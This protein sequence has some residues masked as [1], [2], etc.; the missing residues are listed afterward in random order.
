[1]SGGD[2]TLKGNFDSFYIATI[3]Q[4][5]SNDKKTGILRITDGDKG[6]QVFIKDGTIIY[7]MGS[8]SKDQL[9]YLL[10]TNGQITEEQLQE[11]LR[12]SKEKKQ[13]LGKILVEK[14][15][16]TLA[17]L[18]QFI[19]KQAENVV[20]GLFSWDQGEFEYKDTT[21]SLK[22]LHIVKLNPM[23][24]I[25][26][27][28]RRID[29]MSTPKKLIPNDRIIFKLSGKVNNEEEIVLNEGEWRLLSLLDGSR[30]IRQ[31]VIESGYDDF[32]VYKILYSLLLS[33][34]IEKS[35]AI[36]PEARAEEALIQINDVDSKMVREGLDTLG[37]PRSS[38]VRHALTRIFRDC[39]GTDELLTTVV[40][41]AEKLNN[42]ED[43]LLITTLKEENKIPF[44]H[45]I[46]RLLWDKTETA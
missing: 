33:G 45:N 35:T 27:A 20:F 13:A 10:K 15:F 16:I 46:I 21:L 7:A 9:G 19:Q 36:S 24:V 26:E 28:T 1:M 30:N 38:P 5:L 31:I 34:R 4:L 6:V 43:K 39:V 25:L 14:K 2:M 3:L 40:Q 8:H 44:M 41:E 42:P 22:G 17:E 29:E 18:K 37:L 12:I 11:C 23:Q 32:Q